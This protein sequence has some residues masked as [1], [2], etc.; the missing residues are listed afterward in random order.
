MGNITVKD[1]KVFVP[2]KDFTL[3]KAFYMALGWK[4]NWESDGLAEMEF[5][6]QQL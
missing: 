1:V 2:T 3:C 4:L 6:T 5:G